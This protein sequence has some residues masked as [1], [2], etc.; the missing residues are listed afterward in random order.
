MM[1]S[2]LTLKSPAIINALEDAAKRGC[3]IRVLVEREIASWPQG[4]RAIVI[5]WNCLLCL[6]R[7]LAA[8]WPGHGG[9]VDL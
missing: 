4:G 6:L 9:V 3:K 2:S 7:F 8:S 5:S 1:I